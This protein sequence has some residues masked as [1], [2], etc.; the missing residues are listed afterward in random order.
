MYHKLP[1]MHFPISKKWHLKWSDRVFGRPSNEIFAIFYRLKSWF[2]L[3]LLCVV[4]QCVQYKSKK[5]CFQNIIDL[6]LWNSTRSKQ[7]ILLGHTKIN[8]KNNEKQFWCIEKWPRMVAMNIET[9]NAILMLW[10]KRGYKI[11]P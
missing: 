4:L 9:M 3:G 11:G 1:W 5:Y 8:W 7:P 6:R 2:I 10:I